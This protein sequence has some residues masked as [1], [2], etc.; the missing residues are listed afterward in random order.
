MSSTYSNV[1]LS[2]SSKATSYDTFASFPN[3]IEDGE[4][5]VA[6]DT[7]ILYYW[8]SSLLT[9]IAIV[10]VGGGSSDYKPQTLIT[11]T[12]TEITNKYLIL[13]EAPID[14]PKTRLTVIGGPPQEYG[15]DFVVTSDNADRRVSWD[16]LSLEFLLEVGDKILITHN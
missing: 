14:K 13:A 5:A 4:L 3:G 12:S 15:S 10:G 16:G 1:S 8:D 2:S 11:L 7:D 6:K 9:W